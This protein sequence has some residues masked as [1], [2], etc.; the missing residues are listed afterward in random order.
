MGERGIRQAG[1]PVHV[2]EAGAAVRGLRWPGRVGPC[3]SPVSAVFSS[4]PREHSVLTATRC[5]TEWNLCEIEAYHGGTSRAGRDE[6]RDD[7][8]LV[9]LDG[10]FK[11][12]YD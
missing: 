9:A 2:A 3:G 4:A 5:R 7:S 1:S 6:R 8:G 12:E 11:F 10:W